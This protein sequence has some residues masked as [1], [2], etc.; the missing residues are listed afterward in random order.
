[1][2][3]TPIGRLEQVY[4]CADCLTTWREAEALI[5]ADHRRTVEAFERARAGLLADVRTKLT[6][7]PDE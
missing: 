1:M 6:K 2:T 7:L 4:Y 3:T 5:E